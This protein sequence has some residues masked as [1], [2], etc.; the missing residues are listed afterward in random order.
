[1]FE[2]RSGDFVAR[3]V[4]HHEPGAGGALVERADVA[5]HVRMIVE[6]LG[7]GET[8]EGGGRGW[9]ERAVRLQ[10][11]F[12]AEST[13]S[14]DKQIHQLMPV[15]RAARG[16]DRASPHA[17]TSGDRVRLVHAGSLDPYGRPKAG[18]TGDYPLLPIHVA[19]RPNTC[20]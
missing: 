20:T 6:R 11:L 16:T 17:Q 15:R 9:G 19:G 12:H 10:R 13:E 5:M 4:E 7:R 2:L 14:G 1:M 18:R 8:G 3:L